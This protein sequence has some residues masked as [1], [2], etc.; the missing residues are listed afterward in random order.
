MSI[1]QFLRGT[2]AWTDLERVVEELGDRYELDPVHVRF[3]EAENWL[4]TPLVLN[5][6]YFVKV[7]SRQ[8]A[9]VHR[10]FTAGRNLGA[11]SSG[12]AGFFESV[13]SPAAMARQ[14]LAATE[15]MRDIGVNVPEP[16]EAFGVDDLG[17]LVLEYLPEFSTVDELDEQTIRSLAPTVFEML[18]TMHAHGLAHGDLRGENLLVADGE[19][20]VIDATSVEEDA[21]DGAKPYD[22]ACALGAFTPH[23][24]AGDSVEAA[25]RAYDVDDLLAAREFLDFVN[26]RPDHDFDAAEVKGEIE[27]RAG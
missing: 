6:Q 4:S 25:L 15:R 14:E 13:A 18:A 3:L 10:L 22:I 21:I 20:Y 27:K 23:V 2:I 1:R 8:N 5:D 9:V 19:V 16:V 11:F 24:G 7:V 17:V 12:T 26:I